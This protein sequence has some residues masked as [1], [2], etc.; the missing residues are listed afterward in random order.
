MSQLRADQ[1]SI[2][3][4]NRKQFA[5]AEGKRKKT[6]VF[7]YIAL[8]VGV[9]GLLGS[10]GV[11]WLSYST[12]NETETLKESVVALDEKITIFLD[13]NP[14]KEIENLKTSVEKLNQKVEKLAAAQVVVPPAETVAIETV[15]GKTTPTVTPKNSSTVD[16]LNGTAPPLDTLVPPIDISPAHPTG[17]TPHAP[18]KAVEPVKLTNTTKV[19]A[20]DNTKQIE[21]A[22][23]AAKAEADLLAQKIDKANA[24]AKEASDKTTKSKTEELRKSLMQSKADRYSGRTT[25]GMANAGKDTDVTKTKVEAKNVIAPN[26]IAPK[27]V[28]NTAVKPQKPVPAGKYSVNVI[29]YQ[30]EWFA[31]SKA[32][33]L[34][35]K[36]IPVEVVPVDANNPSTKFRLKVGGF[37]NKTE[38]NAYAEKIKNSNGVN[39]PWVGVSE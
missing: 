20:P 30:Q 9:I 11:G 1:D 21:A 10:A 25:R 14:E 28:L 22:K 37:K 17:E 3:S 31:Q 8:G 39:E 23:A 32:A 12:K 7:S 5:D 19:K 18:M 35:Q 16:L 4:K 33:E 36:G 26:V 27:E 13:K 38:A 2:E 29:S 6:A 24:V 15:N 34:K